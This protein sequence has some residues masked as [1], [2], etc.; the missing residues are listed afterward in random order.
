MLSSAV[1]QYEYIELILLAIAVGV[2]A[3]CGNL[4]FRLAIEFFSLRDH[5]T[6]SVGDAYG[7]RPPLTFDRRGNLA[8]RIRKSCPL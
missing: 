1:G 7:R 2:A 4:G 3:A 6:L 8:W 5:V